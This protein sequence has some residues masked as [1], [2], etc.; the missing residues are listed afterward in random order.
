MPLYRLLQD[1]AFEQAQIEAMAYAFEAICRERQL[2]VGRDEA[3]RERIAQL[4]I[5]YAQRGERDPFKLKQAVQADLKIT[6]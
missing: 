5:D 3:E 4:V 1:Q 2:R 6:D